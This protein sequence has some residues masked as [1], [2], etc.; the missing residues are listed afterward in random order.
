MI[1]S[2]VLAKIEIREIINNYL[3]IAGIYTDVGVG[4]TYTD[5][6]EYTLRTQVFN[7]YA[8]FTCLYDEWYTLNNLEAIITQAIP[9][10]VSILQKNSFVISKV[11][12]SM[13]TLQNKSSFKNKFVSSYSG[14]NAEGDFRTNDY[15]GVRGAF[16]P[17][18]TLALMDVDFKRVLNVIKTDVEKLLKLYYVVV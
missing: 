2:Q 13:E 7:R 17:L 10:I 1:M 15:E 4:D 6:L 9:E 18:E 14:L 11:M 16:R 3:E 12:T 5:I 8:N